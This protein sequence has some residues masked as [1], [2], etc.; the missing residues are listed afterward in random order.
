MRIAL[1][2]LAA[3]LF[4]ASGCDSTLV[5]RENLTPGDVEGTYVGSAEIADGL[6]SRFTMTLTPTAGATS[7][8]E[9]N[10][11]AGNL[12]IEGLLLHNS[13]EY[14]ITGSGVFE[15]PSVSLAAKAPSFGDDG[16]SFA[17]TADASGTVL[18]GEVNG[19]FI[20]LDKQR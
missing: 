2:M 12:D 7:G 18:Q 10:A 16:F 5:P 9:A 3:V 11:T 15:Y 8:T 6:A 1:C 4:A 13:V 14:A 19:Q 17:L 20:K